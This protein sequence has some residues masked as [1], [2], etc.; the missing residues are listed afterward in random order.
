MVDDL[1]AAADSEEGIGRSGA[2]LAGIAKLKQVC[3]HP[4]HFLGDGSALTGRSGKLDRVE[5]PLDEII[6][7]GDKVLCFT[8][9]AEWGELLA[10]HLARRYGVEPLWLHGGVPRKRRD[11]LVARFDDPDAPPIFL[12]SLKAGGTGLNLTA[13]SHVVHLDR[14]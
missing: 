4:A 1:L 5:E 6:D 2:I 3:N 12:L 9:F 10:G 11:D 7:A 13:A 14:W 8:Q